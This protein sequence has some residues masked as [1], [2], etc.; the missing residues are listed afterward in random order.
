ML[1]DAHF[2]Y[3]LLR[4]YVIIIGNMFDN[5]TVV[6]LDSNNIELKRIKV[7]LVYGPK[8]KF[9]T[10]FESD[11][12]LL[13]EVGIILP[14]MSFELKNYTYDASRKQNSLLRVA[15]GDTASRVSS[16]YMGVPYD[17]NFELNIYTTTIDDSNH[18]IEQILPYFNPD[19]TVTVTPIAELGFLKD[20]PILL[21]GVQQNIEYEGNYDSIRY[22]TATLS[23]SLKGYFFGPIST[24]KIIRKSIA[25]I[26][27]DP[28]LVRGNVIRMNLNASGNGNFQVGDTIYQGT[29]YETA[30]AYGF[31]NSWS[32]DN[33]KLVVGGAQGNFEANSTIRGLSTN[34]VYEIASFDATP[35]KLV[36]ITVEP[37]PITAEPDDDYGYST[38]I[39]EFYHPDPFTVDI[40]IVTVDSI[41]MTVDRTISVVNTA[42]INVTYANNTAIAAIVHANQAFA[43]ANAAFAA[44][45]TVTVDSSRGGIPFANLTFTGTAP[46]SDSGD[47]LRYGWTQ[48]NKLVSGWIRLEFGNAGLSSYSKVEID[49]DAMNLPAPYETE[50]LN[51]NEHIT[52]TS[53]VFSATTTGNPVA[54]LGYITKESVGYS[55]SALGADSAYD[56]V[57]MNFSYDAA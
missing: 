57:L 41:N 54:A 14:R 16:G 35:L 6:K 20:I 33:L 34:A 38:T 37:D 48:I 56:L 21:N 40:S 2:Y 1:S 49:F 31:V 43:A 5:I 22:V 18:I 12:N 4:K 55:I 50:G 30:T 10:R 11:P 46:T 23:L 42:Y 51:T 15:K 32:S 3:K 45:N 7:P 27:N 44:A 39:E 8:E 13:R 36:Q 29:K 52:S 47:S 24:P 17:F 25:N 19:Y 9:V 53:A 28:S 26:F